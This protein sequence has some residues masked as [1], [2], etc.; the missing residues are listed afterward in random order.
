V[1]LASGRRGRLR[2]VGG[3]G[4]RALITWFDP[5]GVVAAVIAGVGWGPRA[6]ERPGRAIGAVPVVAA[7]A[8]HGLLAAA[9]FAALLAAGV[10]RSDLGFVSVGSTLHGGSLFAGAGRCIALGFA[11]ENLACGL[12]ALVPLPPLELGVLLWSRLPR[13]PGSRRVAYRLLEEHWGV[14]VVLALLLLPLGGSLPPL[15]SLLDT[16]GNAILGAL[17]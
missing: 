9:G 14:A 15:L 5:F 4:R 6:P 12:L 8:V 10:A 16:V 3:R 13:T 1:A 11:V 2:V 7:V 17:G